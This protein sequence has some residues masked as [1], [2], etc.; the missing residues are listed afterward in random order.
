MEGVVL[1][2]LVCVA[3][4]VERWGG[5]GVARGVKVGMGVSVGRE[6]VEGS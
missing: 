1:G 5:E 2:V 4:K 6:E 3:V